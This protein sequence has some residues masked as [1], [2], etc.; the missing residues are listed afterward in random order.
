MA[1]LLLFRRGRDAGGA[2]LLTAAVWTK[3]FPIVLVPL[4]LLDRMLR[5]RWRNAVTIGGIVGLLSLA[6]NAP[7]AIQ[8]TPDGFRL[9][10]T[11][12]YFFRF[13]R[14]R[15]RE[16]SLWNFLDGFGLSTEQINAYSAVLLMVGIGVTMLLMWRASPPGGRA[17]PDL[18]L[19]A[20]LVALGWL[21]FVNKVYSPQY[22]LWIAVLL[23]LL[24]APSPLAVAFAG[25]ELPFFGASFIALYLHWSLNPA[26]PWFFDQVLLPAMALHQ[27]TVLAVVVWAAARMVRPGG[28]VRGPLSGSPC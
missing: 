3:F 7:F 24:G 26:L 13:T 17:E 10:D 27:G 18:L 1:A 28:T 4:V 2:V 9:R 8:P 20:S 15:T 23:A 22:S 14:D 25:V 6:L 5:R 11:W 16:V 19:P 21:F 12:L